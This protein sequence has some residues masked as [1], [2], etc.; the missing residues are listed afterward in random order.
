MRLHIFF[1]AIIT[2]VF[3]WGCCVP[4]LAQQP[5]PVDQKVANPMPDTPNVNP[6]RQDDISA[7]QSKRNA[8]TPEGGDGEMVVYSSRDESVGK[9][10]SRV[11]THIGNVDVRF[12]IY[13]LQAD[14]VTI[15]EAINKIV[16]EGNVVFDQGNDQRITGTKSEWN[17]KTKL[18][19]FE[20][21]TGFTNQTTDGT[22]IYFT[23][24]RVERVAL[25]EIIVY[26]GKFTACEDA[27]PKWSFTSKKARIKTNDVVK[28]KNPA[29]RV[30]DVPIIPLPYA[31]ISL[32]KEDR[33][34][35]FLTPG[36]GTSDNKGFR[37]SNAY[38]QTLGRSADIT[39]RLDLY[40]ERGIGYGFDARTRANSRSYLNFGFYG[41]KDRIFG[42]PESA[43]N[44]DQGGTFVYAQGVHY[45]S[46]GFVAS[47]DVKLTSNLAFRQVFFDSIQQII[48][49]IEGSQVF[50]NKSWNNYTM[51]VL[52]R[53]QVISIP[54]VR[55]KTRN[56]PSINFEKRPSVLSFFKPAYFSF[57]S[58]LEGVSRRESVDNIS[59]YRLL[60]GSD[61]IVTPAVVQ[62]FDFQPQI[63]IPF[64]TKYFNFTATGSIRSTYYS[65]SLNEFRKVV[66][67]DLV[68]SYGEFEF[69]VRPVALAKNFYN[70][71]GAFQFRHSIEPFLTYRY[72]KGINDFN[73]IIRFDYVD[74]KTDTNEIEYGITNRIFT[75]RYTEAISAEAQKLL[76]EKPN[77]TVNPLSIQPYEIFTFT[78]RGK[79]FFDPYFGGALVP[80][81]RNQIDSITSL[82]PFTFGGVPRRWSPLNVDATY[83]PRRSWFVNTRM[84]IGVQ[85]EWLRDISATVGYNAKL[86]NIFQTF[87][88][89]RAVTLIPSLRQFSF[90]NKEAGTLRGS[91]Y[92]PSVF[93][94]DRNKGVFGGVSLFFDFQ[95]RRESGTSPLVSSTGTIGYAFD[96]CSVV[97]QAYTFNLG[98]RRENRFV[99]S[100]R[101]NGIG[102]FG[103]EQLGGVLY[104]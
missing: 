60:I 80:G 53:S 82:T 48:S 26:N 51:N 33:K 86:L 92:S 59:N 2:A 64:S 83:R 71:N 62:R 25:D 32:K 57:K 11:V 12:G 44:P 6:L 4:A 41:V 54:N 27:V 73:R 81:Q 34:S 66:S 22:V 87:Y 31:S 21:S 35:G 63:S 94:G 30:K 43:A 103:T 37:L 68:R 77:T 74:T 65:N 16:A 40:T 101:L 14:K 28:M 38:F 102:T 10:G 100:F 76:R 61:P 95:N 84:D 58:S 99:F 75:R 69:D 70:K 45:F 88:Y 91:Q 50:V 36:F 90:F 89:T 56:L 98:V 17:Y 49:P 52:M 46:N 42:E 9:E 78:V 20:N 8:P 93:I 97:L 104:R 24:S 15:Y 13:R 29:F 23:A 67:K 5:N 7:P 39:F 18:G 96:C 47:A 3:L 72:I 79:Y 1:K 55:V 85:G 19:Y